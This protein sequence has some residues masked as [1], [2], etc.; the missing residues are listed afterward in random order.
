MTT[1]VPTKP[2]VVKSTAVR[3]VSIAIGAGILVLIFVVYGIHTL[4]D[5]V[6]EGWLS[7]PIVAKE[8]RPDPD[9]QISFGSNG[10]KK[11]EVAGDCLFKVE[12]KDSDEPMTV[13]VDESTYNAYEVGDRF[14]FPRSN[15]NPK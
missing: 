2:F 1:P 5:T 10:L 4:S 14:R 15:Y 6:S 12:L 9:T 7:G 13:W 3:D 11:Q 8:F